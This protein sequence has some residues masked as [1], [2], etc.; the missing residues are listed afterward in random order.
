MREPACDLGGWEAGSDDAF[1]E[2]AEPFEAEVAA[3]WR[4]CLRDAVAVEQ[5]CVAGL[6]TLLGDDRGP[7]LR[8]VSQSEGHAASTFDRADDS[9][10]AYEQWAWMAGVHPLKNA[11]GDVELCELGGHERRAFEVVADEIVELSYRGHE[12]GAVAPR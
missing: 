6:E 11:C 5:E 1:D 4:A 8:K 2:V 12:V 9:R 10:L 7:G 3:A